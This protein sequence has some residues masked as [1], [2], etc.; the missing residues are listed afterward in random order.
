MSKITIGEVKWD[1]VEVPGQQSLKSDFMTLDVGDNKGRVLSNPQQFAVHWIVDDLGKK[2]RVNCATTGCP[3]CLRGQDG[4]KPTARWLIKFLN[5]KE[6]RVQLLEISSQVL[7]GIKT[8]VDDKE[9]WG[10]CSE[11]DVNIKRG[12]PGAQPLYT[13][14]PGRRAPLTVDEKRM[15][16]EFNDRVD[17]SKFITPPTPEVVAEKLGWSTEDSGKN[18]N[19]E[20]KTSNGGGKS[21]S[22]KK[23][24]QDWD[25]DA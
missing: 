16:S 6:G 10:P 8:L 17:I 1:E 19:N 3:V 7:G 2:R 14:I 9:N 4:D 22:V 20:F 25:F 5:R 21:S 23:Q 24:V 11:Y 12:N 15:L 13:V 18:V